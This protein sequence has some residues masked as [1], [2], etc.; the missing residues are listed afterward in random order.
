[1]T[2]RWYVGHK[3]GIARAFPSTITPSESSHGWLFNAVVG[4]FRTRRAAE[5]AASPAA[6]NN[7]HYHHVRD[8]ERIVAE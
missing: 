6:Y 5:W 3:S 2:Q 7:P 4:P 8:A 1:M